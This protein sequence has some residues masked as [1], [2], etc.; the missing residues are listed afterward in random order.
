MQVDGVV[1]QL[2]QRQY[3]AFSR[4]QA[5]AAG[6]SSSLIDRR[7]RSGAWLRAAPG[8]YSLPGVPPGW[9]QRLWIAHLHA[10]ARSAV[11]HEA[12]AAIHEFTGFPRG[13]VVVTV[14][15]SGYRGVH[16]AVVHQITDLT[17]EWCLG[18]RGL[19]V[20][21]PARTILD[22]AALYGFAR[23]EVAAEDAIVARKVTLDRIG[24]CVLTF[25]RRGKPGIGKLTRFLD[26]RADGY[27]PPQSELERM[28]FAALDLLDLPKPVRQ[29]PFPGRSPVGQTVDGAYAD[30]RLVLE[31][32][33]RRWHTRVRDLDRDHARDT[34]AA[35]AGW[36]TL[37]FL[38]ERLRDD[39]LGVARDVADVR[40]TRLVQFSTRQPP[41]SDA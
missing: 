34:E 9:Y 21:D 1:A 13:R 14:P 18:H 7:L 5:K 39:A 30:A 16:G 22:L 27:V 6:A 36:Q 25:A 23:V 10:T 26:A 12:A 32:D 31:A 38:Y 24:T 15:H 37:R 11:S 35:R 20:T 29:Y 17:P 2:A 8:V 41:E 40:A 19:P 4:A 3:G 33:G 28:L